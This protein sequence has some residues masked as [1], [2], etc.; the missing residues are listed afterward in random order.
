MIDA[1]IYAIARDIIV[2][3][4]ACAILGGAVTGLVLWLVL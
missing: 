3:G 2:I 4:I 1:T